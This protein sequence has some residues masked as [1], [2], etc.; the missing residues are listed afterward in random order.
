[1]TEKVFSLEDVA[2][3]LGISERTVMRE[4]QAGKIR[5][6]KAGRALRF[7]HEAVEQYIKD[8]EVSPGEPNVSDEDTAEHRVV[9]RKQ[10][11]AVA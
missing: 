2:K 10:E 7:T 3:L 8:Q 1:M 6:F 5:A 11:E 4:I 9:K